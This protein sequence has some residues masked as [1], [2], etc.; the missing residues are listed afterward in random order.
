MV[1]ATHKPPIMASRFV[2][3]LINFAYYTAKTY[4]QSPTCW[5]HFVHHA[6][7]MSVSIEDI[8][9]AECKVKD[10]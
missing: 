1:I 4:K 8:I 7:I 10:L 3:F 2:G 5:I 6:E 9:R